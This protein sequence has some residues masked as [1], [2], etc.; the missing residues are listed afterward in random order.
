MQVHY[1]EDGGNPG[2]QGQEEG[3]VGR[4]R[5]LQ[6]WRSYE[7]RAWNTKST[8]KTTV[9]QKRKYLAYFTTYRYAKNEDDVPKP[10]YRIFSITVKSRL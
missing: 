6:K 1:A 7:T 4:L 3:S 10:F 5:V 9:L 2:Q 8:N